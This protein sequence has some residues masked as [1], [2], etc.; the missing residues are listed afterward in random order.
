MDFRI[1]RNLKIM[2][3]FNPT[4]E[5]TALNIFEMNL[6]ISKGEIALPLYQRDLSWTLKQSI[7]LL[8]YELLGK[9]AI[10]PVSFCADVSD[11]VPLVTFISRTPIEKNALS[12]VK[13]SVVDGQQRLTTNYKVY[14]NDESFRNIA[15]DLVA[16]KFVLVQDNF[17]EYQMQ[18]GILLN[19][20]DELFM[21]QLSSYPAEAQTY[22]MAV[23]QKFKTYMYTIH[24]AKRLNEKEQIDWFQVLNNAGSTVS[25]VQLA[26]SKM[27]SH[28]YDI[29]DYIHD[30]NNAFKAKL[31]EDLVDKL[32]PAPKTWQ[33]YPVCALNPALELAVGMNHEKRYTPISSDAKEGMLCR[34][35]IPKIKECVDKTMNALHKALDFIVDNDLLDIASRME[36]YN[37][38]LGFFI[39]HDKDTSPNIKNYLIDWIKNVKFENTTNTERREI[40]SSLIKMK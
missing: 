12:K 23:R 7:A 34:Q 22:L 10:S 27:K 38:L 6:M 15:L 25:K 31:P 11:D 39:F 4:K 17:K 14:I 32:Y 3:G 13:Y 24:I 21:K 1:K 19:K 26:F 36:Y 33:S 9:A 30:Y 35:G 20:D 37:Y 16:G 28:G 18:A 8:N 5:S 40:F 29:Y 2:S